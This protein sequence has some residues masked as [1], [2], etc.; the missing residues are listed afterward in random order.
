MSVK[1]VVFVVSVKIESR[2]SRHCVIL[3]S[4]I[5]AWAWQL[6]MFV[7]TAVTAFNGCFLVTKS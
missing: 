4:V 1:V 3:G 7:L 2:G 5:R 6:S